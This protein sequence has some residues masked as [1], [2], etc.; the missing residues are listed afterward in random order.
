MMINNGIQ[1]VASVYAP[2]HATPARRTKAAEH[3]QADSPAFMVSSEARSFSDMLQELQGMNDIRQDKVAAIQ[4]QI[5]AGTYG[6]SSSDV[7][8]K[9]LDT[10]F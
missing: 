10:R 9:L 3:P 1:S 2:T 6:P 4:Q 7:A 8:A 5:T